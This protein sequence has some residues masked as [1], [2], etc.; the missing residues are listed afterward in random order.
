MTVP[1][2]LKEYNKDKAVIAG[3][4]I[5]ATI[6]LMASA[7]DCSLFSVLFL[8]GTDTDIPFANQYALDFAMDKAV[9]GNDK[10]L[11][12][13]INELMREPIV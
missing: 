3:Y 5:G 10:K 8:T 9:M 12:Q 6:T 4:S 1:N 7:K 11:I 13:K 2:G